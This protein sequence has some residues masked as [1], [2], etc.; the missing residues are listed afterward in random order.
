[1]AVPTIDEVMAGIKQRA[2]VERE[3]EAMPVAGGAGGGHPLMGAMQGAAEVIDNSPIGKAGKALSGTVDYIKKLPSN[4]GKGTLD[5]AVAG[6]RM[7][8][9]GLRDSLTDAGDYGDEQS[10]ASQVLGDE[11]HKTKIAPP[12]SAAGMTPE[13]LRATSDWRNEYQSERNALPLALDKQ[14]GE[15]YDKWRASLSEDD[16]L[17][18]TITQGVAQ[19]A[20]PFTAFSKAFGVSRAFSLANVGKAAAAEGAAVFTGFDPNA[21]RLTELAELGLQAEGKFGNAL[22]AIAPEGGLLNQYIDWM[23]DRDGETDA[24]ARF[25]NSI[26]SLAGSAAVAGL[27][28]VA[29]L[30]F[31]AARNMGS[32]PAKELPHQLD[33]DGAHVKATDENFGT[34]NSFAKV[35]QSNVDKPVS[36]HALVEALERN[37]KGDTE[38]GAFYKELLG[39]LKDKKLGGKTTVFGDQTLAPS[40]TA[41]GSYALGPDAVK[42]YPGAFKDGP[43]RLLHTFTHEAVHSATIRELQKSPEAVVKIKRLFQRVEKEFT[44]RMVQPDAAIRKLQ[45]LGAA[46]KGWSTVENSVSG[47]KQHYGMT[48]PV[49]FI[50]EIESNPKFRKLMKEMKIDGESAWDKYKKVIGGILGIGA[51]AV[52]PEFDKL[53]DP[54]QQEGA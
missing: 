11:E 10:T 42:L 4:L 46:P 37:I 36:T 28:K 24:E 50:A 16:D 8:W 19:F 30:T 35:L 49:E 6:G 20:V 43:E 33:F 32:A 3:V 7:L 21:G 51:L 18:D 25:K 23:N 44:A 39:R 13:Q 12:P 40:G 1:M 15:A 22:R 45:E 17:S 53:M 31:R 47:G 9:G 2:Q 5:A 48:E 26:D 54:E 14:A 41:R 38:T 34:L 29:G 52:N 27:L